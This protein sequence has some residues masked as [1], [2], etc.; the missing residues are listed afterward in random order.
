MGDF[1]LIR[2]YKIGCE[3]KSGIVENVEKLKFIVVGGTFWQEFRT[4]KEVSN[5]AA[6]SLRW[7]TSLP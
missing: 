1:L 5:E 3:D 7:N 4:W 6:L 2:G